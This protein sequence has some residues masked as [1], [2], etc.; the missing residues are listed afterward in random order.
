[1]LHSLTITRTRQQMQAVVTEKRRLA[2]Y[3]WIEAKAN[4]DAPKIAHWVGVVR[5]LDYWLECLS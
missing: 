5:Q 3:A 4:S 1:M 2:M